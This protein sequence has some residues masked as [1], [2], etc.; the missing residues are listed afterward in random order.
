MMVDNPRD[1]EPMTSRHRLAA[2]AG[3]LALLVTACSGSAAPSAT[4]QPTAS[5][6]IAG[7][8][9]TPEAS[10]ALSLA[11]SASAT[12]A[13]SDDPE[14][15]QIA[16]NAEADS[17]FLEQ[18]ECE[19]LEDGYRLRF[20]D[21]WWTNTAFDETAPCVWFSPTSF[22]VDGSDDV[23]PEIAITITYTEGDSGS[24]ETVV[25]R[26]FGIVGSTQQ[27]VRVEYRGA[28]GQGGTMPPEWRSTVYQI[29]L[30]PTPEQ[31]PNLVVRTTT[32][33]GGDYELNKAVL[34]RIMATIEFIGTIE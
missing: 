18:D 2:L 17:L 12:P 34:D 24:F 5:A 6:S 3:A 28:A 13:G 21:A 22:E 20:P 19:N 23:P 14:T 9:E 25:S 31:G 7:P 10:P 27:A 16:S 15:F 8:S 30:G 4:L 33:M 1:E 29:Q 32:D 11:P 26:D